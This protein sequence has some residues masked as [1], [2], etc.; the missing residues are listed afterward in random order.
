MTLA[1][2]EEKARH[3]SPPMCWDL[4]SGP[5]H[6]SPI[7]GAIVPQSCHYKLISLRQSPR[8]TVT[9]LLVLPTCVRYHPEWRA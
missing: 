4:D 8:C 7:G 9:W 5:L 6:K 1:G 2:D 3:P